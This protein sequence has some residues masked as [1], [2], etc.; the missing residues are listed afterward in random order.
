MIVQ[1]SL[2]KIMLGLA[3]YLLFA[4]NLER[5]WKRWCTGIYMY[6]YIVYFKSTELNSKPLQKRYYEMFICS[7]DVGLSLYKRTVADW[8][9]LFSELAYFS[10]LKLLYTQ[11]KNIC[12]WIN[13][14]WEWYTH[15][16]GYHSTGEHIYS[17]CP[18]GIVLFYS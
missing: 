9:S 3:N 2:H 1:K 6:Q 18:M 17:S 7:A 8:M 15:V 16:L 5:K 14:F 11:K 12:I 4:I 10:S 13:T